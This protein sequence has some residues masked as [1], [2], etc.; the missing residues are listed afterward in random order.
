VKIELADQFE[1]TA[2]TVETFAFLT[3]PQR[4][5]PILPF[6]KELKDVQ[7][8]AFT[9]EL[10]VG[11]PQV[12]GRVTIEVKLVESVAPDRASYKSSG[13]HALGIVDSELEFSVAANGT[14]SIVRWHSA[15]IVNGTL[16]SL[17]QGILVPLAKRQIKLLV[18]ACQDR[19]GTSP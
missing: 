11:I 12:R 14:G 10:E 2:A 13:R 19:L 5:A 1:V 17:A 16:A 6:F 3:D 4:F 15:S 8:D 9:V 7:P 18:R